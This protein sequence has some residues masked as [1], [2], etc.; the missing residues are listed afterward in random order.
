MIRTLRKRHLYTWLILAVLLPVGFFAAYSVIPKVEPV[1][2]RVQYF[3]QKVI[4]PIIAEADGNNDAIGISI[5]STKDK[6]LKQLEVEVR[7]PIASPSAFIYVSNRKTESI[8]EAQIVG[9][10]GTK[11]RHFI[12]LDATISAQSIQTILIY[13]KIKNELIYKADL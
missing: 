5:R 10:L 11:G 2:Q 1:D 3:D 6:K 12:T 7:T 8:E 13:D 9:A 4:G